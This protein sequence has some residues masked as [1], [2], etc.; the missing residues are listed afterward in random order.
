[1]IKVYY[2][3]PNYLDYLLSSRKHIPSSRGSRMKKVVTKFLSIQC[4]LIIALL[5]LGQIAL[6]DISIHLDKQTAEINEPITLTITKNNSQNH[7]VLDI[8]PIQ[9]DFDILSTSQSE[10]YSVINGKVSYEQT[11][12]IIVQAKHLG[13]LEIPALSFGKE[14]TLKQNITI[15]DTANKQNIHNTQSNKINKLAFIKVLTKPQDPYIN[16][17]VTYTVQLY[18]K[19]P[20]INGRYEAPEV[21]NGLIF[22]LGQSRHSTTTYNDEEYFIE[23]QDYALFPQQSGKVSI[24]P[25]KF[26]AV[27]S[28]GVPGNTTIIGDEVDLNVKVALAKKNWLPVQ[29]LSLTENYTSNNNQFYL[30]ETLVRNVTIS[31]LGMPAQLIAKLDYQTPSK[32]NLYQDENIFQNSIKDNL[33]LGEKTTKLTYA[34][35]KAG[36]VTIPKIECQWFD[37]NSQTFKTATLPERH[38]TILPKN[39]I[40]TKQDS[41]KPSESTSWSLQVKLLITLIIILIFSQLI[42]IYIWRFKP[43]W[44][45]TNPLITNIKNAC[46]NN[47]AKACAESLLDF[48]AQKYPQKQF[49]TIVDF[50]KYVDNTEF[51]AVIAELYKTL[52]ETPTSAN[53]QGN[54]L[55][56]EFKK[57]SFKKKKLAKGKAKKDIPELY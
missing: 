52:Y 7:G 40:S 25:P 6:A 42:T 33:I 22:P 31:A 44:R 21:D 26:T 36:E 32:A 39:K 55:W 34:F 56:T 17:Q 23:E 41:A 8:T 27:I 49:M 13:L 16:Q 1:M 50:S 28:N 46:D 24:K 19:F 57:L 3:F 30:G 43:N 47:D 37:T 2:K 4:K 45:F 5:L 48:A 29:E 14:Q 11:W 15:N 51:S 12:S 10:S 18:N 53:W 20:L 54:I 9:K 38:I 35:S